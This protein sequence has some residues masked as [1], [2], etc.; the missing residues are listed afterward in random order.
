M[1]CDMAPITTISEHYNGTRSSSRH[2]ASISLRLTR[3]YGYA[4]VD[5]GVKKAAARYFTVT[6]HQ[7]GVASAGARPRVAT[8]SLARV[9]SAIYNY[10]INVASTTRDKATWEMGH[11][12]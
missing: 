6:N 4:R 3:G 10:M 11:A 5:A 7:S 8:R 2:P 9:L 12:A 1:P